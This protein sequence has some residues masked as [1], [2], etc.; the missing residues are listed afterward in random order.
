MLANL[1]RAAKMVPDPNI[2]AAL[3]Q[4]QTDPL[5]GPDSPRADTVSAGDSN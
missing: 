2:K 5:F 1:E 3:Q 4:M